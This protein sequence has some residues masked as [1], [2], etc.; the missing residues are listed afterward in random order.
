M[1]DVVLNEDAVDK[2]LER[3][4]ERRA[5]RGSAGKLEAEW[6]LSDRQRLAHERAQNRHAWHDYFMAIA[7]SLALRS[8]EYQR[9]AR[10]LLEEGAE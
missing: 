3:L 10:A 2:E 7:E 8:A 9:R 4:V 5:D 6:K 1:T